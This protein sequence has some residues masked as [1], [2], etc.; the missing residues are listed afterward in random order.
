VNLGHA[1]AG[2]ASTEQRFCKPLPYIAEN[3]FFAL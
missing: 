2:F 3:F 1:L